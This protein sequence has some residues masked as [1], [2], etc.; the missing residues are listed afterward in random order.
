[1]NSD[2]TRALLESTIKI[3]KRKLEA[4][5]EEA[6]RERFRRRIERLRNLL[7]ELFPEPDTVDLSDHWEEI[8]AALERA[9]GREFAGKPLAPGVVIPRER[10]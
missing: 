1:M 3:E 7:E 5:A 8:L 4:A 10:R 9:V 6:L 2:V